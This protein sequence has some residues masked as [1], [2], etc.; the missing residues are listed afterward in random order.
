KTSDLFDEDEIAILDT[1]MHGYLLNRRA[2]RIA[3]SLHQ[4]SMMHNKY[5]YQ[6]PPIVTLPSTG[7]PLEDRIKIRQ[8]ERDNYRRAVE[9]AK[10]TNVEFPDSDLGGIITSYLLSPT[11]ERHR[12]FAEDLGTSRIDS[13]EKEDVYKRAKDE[14]PEIEPYDIFW[15]VPDEPDWERMA[16]KGLDDQVWDML[17][18]PN[19]RLLNPGSL[20]YVMNEMKEKDMTDREII[21]T[22]AKKYR[23]DH[24]WPDDLWK[25]DPLL[26]AEYWVRTLGVQ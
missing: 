20:R 5:D 7:I 25:N 18:T 24:A 16:S 19:D 11:F 22:I 23:E 14:I 15:G 8:D 9:L 13:F 10:E 21:A 12:R 17:H 1:T 26:R 3:Y 6:G 4:K 2:F